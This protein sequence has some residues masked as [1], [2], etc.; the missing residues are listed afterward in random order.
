MAGRRPGLKTFHGPCAYFPRPLGPCAII[1]IAMIQSV[2]PVLDTAYSVFRSGPL[3]V[4]VMTGRGVGITPRFLPSGLNTWMPAPCNGH[5]E[6]PGR[7]ER[8]AVAASTAFELGEFALVGERAILLDVKRR[9][10]RSVGDVKMLFIGGE[11]DAVRVDIL[12]VLG[13][14]AFRVRMIRRRP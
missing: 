2:L 3:K 8:A 12:T 11:N 5:V 9:E 4:T 10:R 7:I 13:D 6:A 14:L 1:G